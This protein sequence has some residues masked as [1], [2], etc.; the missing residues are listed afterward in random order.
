[1]KI[2]LVQKSIDILF[3][4][5]TIGIVVKIKSGKNTRR[6]SNEY[7]IIYPRTGYGKRRCSSENGYTTN[8]S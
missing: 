6:V 7:Q 5:Y 3:F 4:K 1:M 2:I 8:G